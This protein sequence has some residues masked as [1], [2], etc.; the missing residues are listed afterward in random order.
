MLIVEFCKFIN[1]KYGSSESSL[2]FSEILTARTYHNFIDFLNSDEKKLEKTDIVKY[3]SL[4]TYIKDKNLYSDFPVVGFEIVLN[5][6]KV[7]SQK[8]ELSVGGYSQYFG[9]KN[10]KNYSKI[11]KPIKNTSVGLII[12][13]GIDISVNYKFDYKNETS[14]NLLRDDIES[15]VYHELNHSYEHY[16]RVIKKSKY[17]KPISDRS[18]N[19]SITYSANNS[20]KFNKE[21]WEFWNKNFLKYL[22][23]GEFHELNANIQEITFYIK[24]YPNKRLDE[25]LIYKNADEMEK[26]DSEKFYNE[27]VS[28]SS[29]FTANK[30]KNMWISVYEKQ[31]EKQKSKPIIPISTLKNMDGLEFIKFWGKKINMNGKYIKRKIGKIKNSINEKV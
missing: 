22:Y 12:Q 11:V 20:W 8:I 17:I 1:E 3:N 5:F 9:N 2:I 19:T 18:F 27:I 25:F 29:D 23:I 28:K 26:F 31:I 7:K 6:K 10:W 30:L 16:K 13:I 15:T 24:K 21:L 14:S 4:R